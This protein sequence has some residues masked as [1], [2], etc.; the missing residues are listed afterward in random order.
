M[1]GRDIFVQAWYQ[2][3]ISVIDFTDSSNPFEIAFFDR[4]PINADKLVMGGYWSAYWYKGFVYGTE[5][6]RGLDVLELQ[7]SE[8]LTRN[9]IAA[10]SLVAPD[11][12]NVQQQRRI[13]WSNRPVVARAYLDQLGREDSL[14]TAQGTL[15]SDLLDRTDQIMA[16][17]TQP[18]TA[19]AEELDN[20]ATSIERDS[21]RARGLGRA[22]LT[23]LA[24]IMKN[25]AA[26]LR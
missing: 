16:D 22:R 14:S 2:G 7:P 5:I 25:L 10:A 13:D 17:G 8:Y 3:G 18:S 19:I 6:A 12:F 4:G 23:A 15:L 20:A 21:G 1:P 11:T 26:R 9:E 24:E